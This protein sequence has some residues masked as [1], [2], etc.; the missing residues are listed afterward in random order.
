MPAYQRMATPGTLMGLAA[1]LT[2]IAEEIA[3]MAEVEAAL[4]RKRRGRPTIAEQAARAAAAKPV[5]ADT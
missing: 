3:R 2:S 5:T 1:E 4:A